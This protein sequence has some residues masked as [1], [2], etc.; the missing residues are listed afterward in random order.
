ME[1]LSWSKYWAR[2]CPDSLNRTYGLFAINY[3]RACFLG[4]FH[5]EQSIVKPIRVVLTRGFFEPDF[6]WKKIFMLIISH[7]GVLFWKPDSI[8]KLCSTWNNL[9][10]ESVAPLYSGNNYLQFLQVFHVEQIGVSSII[11]TKQINNVI[12]FYLRSFTLWWG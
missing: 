3:H 9:I 11:L 12:I 7:R 6:A 10:Y 4:L 1:H 8:I 5:V 2:Y